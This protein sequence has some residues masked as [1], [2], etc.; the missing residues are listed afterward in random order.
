M[1]DWHPNPGPGPQFF[2]ST[3]YSKELM[4]SAGG[5]P[6]GRRLFL[7]TVWCGKSGR[8]TYRLS[9][10]RTSHDAFCWNPTGPRH[11]RTAGGAN[12][13][14]VEVQAW[15]EVACASIPVGWPNFHDT[16]MMRIQYFPNGVYRMVAWG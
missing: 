1:G 13:T 11:E 3:C 10:V 9:A 5:G 15:V 16:L 14:F 6:W 4:R 2:G 7:Y 12:F 8:I